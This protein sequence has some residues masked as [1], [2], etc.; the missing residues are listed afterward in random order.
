MS[1]EDSVQHVARIVTAD[2][3]FTEAGVYSAMASAS[4]P[5]RE[6]DLAYKFTQAAWGRML[7]DG[8]GIKFSDDYHC[9]DRNGDV[10]A[11]GKL[12]EEPHFIAAK[13]LGKR[14]GSQAGFKR[15]AARSSDF[16]A[17]NQ[18]LN[19][20]S[21]P[22]NLVSAPLM[23]FLEAPTEVGITK[24]RRF[25]KELL[26]RGNPNASDAPQSQASGQP[27]NQPLQRTGAAEK[28]S[29]FQKLFGRDPGR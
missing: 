13:N 8:M 4:V 23:L 7:L 9:L 27:Y 1:P 16:H 21:Q 11:S 24:A 20:G 29:W 12:S 2:T 22:E 18:A 5:N 19:T 3:Q 10:I 17:V 14:C 25:M 6:A 15:L 26:S 28:R